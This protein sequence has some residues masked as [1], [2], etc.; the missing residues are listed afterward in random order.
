MLLPGGDSQ[1]RPTSWSA[2]LSAYALSGTDI[3][4]A[5]TPVQTFLR[6]S[7]ALPGTDL[8]SLLPG[9]RPIQPQP[10]A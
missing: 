4:Y 8:A 6:P 9:M 5:P 10:Q 7:Y 3:P 1:G 2:P